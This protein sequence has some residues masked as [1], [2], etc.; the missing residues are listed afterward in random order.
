[1][2]TKKIGLRAQKWSTIIGSNQHNRGEPMWPSYG[3]LSLD[4]V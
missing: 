3:P 4:F 1:M 2:D